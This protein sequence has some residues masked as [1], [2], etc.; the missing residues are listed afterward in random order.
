MTRRPR[1]DDRPRRA[2]TQLGGRTRTEGPAALAAPL[3]EAW[4]RAA[5]EDLDALT[6]GFHSWPARMPW[7][8][9]RTLLE[10]WRPASVLDPFCGGGT[11][12]V[13]ARVAGAEA[14]GADLNPLASRL[15]AVKAEPRDAAAGAR[16]RRLAR[17]VADASAAR[18]RGRVPIEVQL[19]RSELRWYAPHVVK[20]LGGLLG[21]LRAAATGSDRLALEMVFSALLVKVSRQRADTA[22]RAVER[23]IRK[24]LVTELFLRK[25]V[26]L[27]ERQGRLA[28]VVKGPAPT[29]LEADVRALPRRLEG[30][31]VD[32]ILTSPPYGGTHDYVRHHAR[33]LAW[34]GLDPSGLARGEIGARRR[35]SGRDAA[36]RWDREVEAM[37]RAL[38]RLLHPEGRA[39]LVLGDAQVGDR[40]VGA[41]AQ[42]AALA[43]AAG[44]AVVASAS[45]ERPDH[46]GGAARGEHAIVLEA[47][48]GRVTPPASRGSPG[49]AAPRGAPARR[50]RSRGGAPRRSGTRAGRAGPRGSEPSR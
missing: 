46:L 31:Q 18:V 14:V 39:V 34:L 6:H 41:R 4:A 40:R 36:A 27:V 23:R 15:T 9:A 10:A 43:P 37:L 38:R 8:I 42:L 28:E 44:L 11:V 7:P 1:A 35:A 5:E 33:R 24:G 17:E 19:P 26:E 20:E 49:R 16:L 13:E 2:M 22:E 32:L 50:R 47:T 12:V 3:A 29:L 21:E 45:Q 48:A 25:A 30:R